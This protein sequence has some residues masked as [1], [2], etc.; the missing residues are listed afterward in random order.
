MSLNISVQKCAR[1]V[2]VAIA[3]INQA[4]FISEFSKQLLQHILFH[5][6]VD[7]MKTDEISRAICNPDVACGVK[8]NARFSSY[9]AK[10][11]ALDI[12]ARNISAAVGRAVVHENDLPVLE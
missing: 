10:A 6:I 9:I 1:L 5:D 4:N 7:D 8:R 2:Y 11:T 3:A 12:G